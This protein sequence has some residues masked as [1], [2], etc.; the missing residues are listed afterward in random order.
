MAK[1]NLTSVQ[2]LSLMVSIYVMLG[3][4]SHVAAHDRDA[5]ILLISETTL[6]SAWEPLAAWKTAQGKPTKIITLQEIEQTFPGRDIQ[7]KIR[8]AV[9]HHITEK[10]LAG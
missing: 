3:M 6:E 1:L 7:E 10:A 9:R 4:M 8:L 2:P 5:E